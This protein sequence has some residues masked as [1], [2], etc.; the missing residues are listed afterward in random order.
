MAHVPDT[1]ARQN[2]RLTCPQLVAC[3]MPHASV[4]G[5]R[6]RAACVLLLAL[7][8]AACSGGG[9]GGGRGGPAAAVVTTTTVELRPFNDRIRALGTAQARESVE[10]TAK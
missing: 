8:A 3:P 7:S 1:P 6:L 2:R 10:V 9:E 4:P 5:P